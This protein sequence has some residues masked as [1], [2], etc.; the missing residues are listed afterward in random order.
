LCCRFCKAGTRVETKNLWQR[1]LKDNCEVLRKDNYDLNNPKNTVGWGRQNSLGKVRTQFQ[2]RERAR[3]VVVRKQSTPRGQKDVFK[4][5]L[6]FIFNE[7]AS[8]FE[9][10]PNREF[11]ILKNSDYVKYYAS[12]GMRK[13]Q[14]VKQI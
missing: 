8:K 13:I 1:F 3:E 10:S 12:G 9:E 2:E 6:D 11:P 5:R 7:A 14:V 4:A